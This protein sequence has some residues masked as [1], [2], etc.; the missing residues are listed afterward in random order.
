MSIEVNIEIVKGFFAAIGTG[1]KQ[2]LLALVTEDIEW[3]IP[4]EEW[5]LWPER[6]AATLE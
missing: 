1:D 3:I 2:R 6:T 4:G 5:L